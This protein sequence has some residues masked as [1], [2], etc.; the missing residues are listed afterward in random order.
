MSYLFANTF[1]IVWITCDFGDTMILKS[2]AQSLE[3]LTADDV[4]NWLFS[5]RA[6]AEQGD[7][8]TNLAQLY[9]S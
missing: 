5:A 3:C 1:T 9:Y 8:T 6:G 4:K 2:L 7:A